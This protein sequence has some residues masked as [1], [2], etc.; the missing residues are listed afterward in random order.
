MNRRALAALPV[1]RTRAALLAEVRRALE[2]VPHGGHVIVA[3][4]GGPDSTAL[5]FLAAEARSDLELRLAHVAHGLREAAQD[6][7]EA[8]LVAQHAAWL[9]VEAEQLQVVVS[10]PGGP[11]EAA[12]RARHAALADLADRHRAVA[13][14]LG[15][16]AD[17]QAETTLLR[18]ARGTGVAGAAGMRPARDR[19]HRPLLRLRRADV[20][21][22]VAGEGLPVAHDV[23]NDDTRQAR[24]TV[25]HEVLPLLERIA[26]DPVGALTRFAALAGDDAAALEAAAELVAWRRYGTLIALDRRHLAELHPAIVRRVL[27]RV[28]D[29]PAGRPP[30]AATVERVRTAAPG[31]RATLP[32]GI[33]LEVTDELIL[34]DPDSPTAEGPD[35][36]RCPGRTGWA[37][38]GVSLLARTPE[39]QGV[40][41]L[42]GQLALGLPEVWRPLPIPPERR[43][44]L[45]G[46]DLQRMEVLLPAAAELWVR[47][48]VDGDRIVTGP[49]TRRLAEVFRDAHVPRPLRTRWPV[50]VDAADQPVWV[51][52]LAVDARMHAAGRQRP[53]AVLTVVAG[54]TA[55]GPAQ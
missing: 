45:P 15:H 53:A 30:T 22:F 3:C 14:L 52:G 44:A 17:D 42:A 24:A 4:S 48:A 50:L 47:S 8:D 54:D 5:A 1:G 26:G 27:R 10:G 20:H 55:A 33:M 32:A 25:R 16:T 6:A 11:E 38:A 34:L 40:P 18:L 46:A 37:A 51:P 39:E 9:G 31:T 29:D 36:V 43:A 23:T 12:R 2:P 49:G 21:A 28:L 13:I 35:P 41:P 7:Q 19:L